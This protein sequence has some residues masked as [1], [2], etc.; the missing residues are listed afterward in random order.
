MVEIKNK[1]IDIEKIQ[2]NPNLDVSLF[3]KRSSSKTFKGYMLQQMKRARDNN[4]FELAQVIEHF[5]KKAIEYEKKDKIVIESWRGKGGIKVWATP[6]TISVEF[7]GK[8]DKDEKPNIQRNEYTKEEVNKMIVCI[9][10]L[11]D[12]YNNR[13]PSRNLGEEYFGGNWDLKVFSKRSDHMMFTHLLNILDYYK[14]IKYSRAGFTTVINE[15]KEIQ[16][17]LK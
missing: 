1:N 8:R 14:I 17:V 3:K 9:N 6:D 2:P 5:Y 11:K 15:V 12:Q 16:E 13:I 10:K 7:A 4:N